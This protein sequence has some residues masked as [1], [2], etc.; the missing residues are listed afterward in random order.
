MTLV[1]IFILDDTISK[2]PTVLHTSDLHASP[3]PAEIQC[4]GTESA[5]PCFAII[6]KKVSMTERWEFRVD[7]AQGE[8]WASCFERP[9]RALDGQMGRMESREVEDRWRLVILRRTMGVLG[10]RDGAGEC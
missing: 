5:S 3:T 8:P 6:A 10:Q 2:L 1:M 4:S 9:D 7:Q